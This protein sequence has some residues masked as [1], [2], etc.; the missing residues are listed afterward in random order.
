MVKELPVSWEQW[1]WL[2]QTLSRHANAKIAP[3]VIKL[4]MPGVRLLEYEDND[5]IVAENDIG[6]AMYVIYQGR[7]LVLRKGNKLAELET[8]DFFG[9]ISLLIRAPRTATVKAVKN[10]QVFELSWRAV[11]SITECFPELMQAM[12]AAAAKRM[13]ELAQ[14]DPEA[15]T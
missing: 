3:E 13:E 15:T 8:G 14:H 5:A 7:V 11:S 12:Q 10:C 6:H 4:V 2:G 1:E 9:E